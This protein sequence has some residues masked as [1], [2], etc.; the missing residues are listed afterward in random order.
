M[1]SSGLAT[2]VAYAVA[3]ETPFLRDLHEQI[4]RNVASEPYPEVQGPIRDRGGPAG[5]VVRQGYIVA[6][7]GDVERVDMT[8]SVAKS[9]LGALAGLALDRG[10]IRDPDE[11]VGAKVT[12]RGY[13]SAHN[14]DHLAL[15]LHPDERVGGRCGM[16]DVA[17]GGAGVTALRRRA[18]SRSNDV[19]EPGALNL[20]RSSP[21]APGVR[22]EVMGMI[23]ADTGVARCNS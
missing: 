12:D 16:P 13:T 1:D 6:Q 15:H 2:A 14:A 7:W 9:Y 3:H 21:P 23:G 20:L 5:V 17:T 18:P 19:R 22:T 4:R 10:L 11:P 8:F